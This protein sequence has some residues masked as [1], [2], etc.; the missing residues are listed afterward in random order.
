VAQSYN[1][2]AVDASAFRRRA[3]LMDWRHKY[4]QVNLNA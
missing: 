3:Q 2:L 1:I 4:A